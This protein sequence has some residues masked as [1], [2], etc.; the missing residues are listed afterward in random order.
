MTTAKLLEEKNQNKN[1]NCCIKG[2]KKYKRRIKEST[3]NRIINITWQETFETH[4]LNV[5]V[6]ISLF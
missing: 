5:N 2:R 6:H 4:I 1:A 3:G